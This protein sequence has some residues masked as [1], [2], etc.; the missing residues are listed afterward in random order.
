MMDTE[1]LWSF[2]RDAQVMIDHGDVEDR[3]R[4]FLSTSLSS[5]FPDSPWWVRAH[6][7]GSEEHV[8]FANVHGT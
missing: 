6:A 8:R 2:V 5:I 3:L 1:R 7:L 4:H